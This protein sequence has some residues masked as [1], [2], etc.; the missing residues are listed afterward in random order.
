MA[1]RGFVGKRT[2]ENVRN[3]LKSV[4]GDRLLMM[5]IIIIVI[6]SADEVEICFS[7]GFLAAE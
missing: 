3:R 1:E 6:P 7:Y 4:I 2:S 5:M